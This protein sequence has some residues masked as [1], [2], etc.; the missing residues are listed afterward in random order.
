MVGPP[1]I[2]QTALIT[3]F[4]DT[5]AL[6]KTKSGIIYAHKSGYVTGVEL[7]GGLTGVIG[8]AKYKLEVFEDVDMTRTNRIFIFN[9]IDNFTQ[10]GII[11]DSA[12]NAISLSKNAINDGYMNKESPMT[13]Y[14]YYKLSWISGTI[15]TAL[16]LAL[17]LTTDLR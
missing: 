12:G 4:N 1:T 5:D 8:T 14:V 13:Y 7:R 17:K 11:N 6:T 9:N 2:T 16:T 10:N 3:G 15:T